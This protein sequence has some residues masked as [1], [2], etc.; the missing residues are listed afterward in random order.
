M[1]IPESHFE[2]DS[3]LTEL[4]RVQRWLDDLAEWHRLND[5]T[6]YAVQLCM[7][8]ALANVILHGYCGQP[9]HLIVIRT[10]NSDGTL[11]LVIEDKAPFFNP[12]F[13]SPPNGVRPATL[14]SVVPGGN[15]IRLVHRF[16]GSIAYE[17]LPRA[18]A[19]RLDLRFRAVIT[20]LSKLASMI[21][22]RSRCLIS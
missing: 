17:E 19:L 5:E 6:R 13:P 18:I 7:E 22:L 10:W 1:D 9:G 21:A 2:L 8:E 16:A 20:F 3:T 15:G 12:R 14:E 4:V 11:Y